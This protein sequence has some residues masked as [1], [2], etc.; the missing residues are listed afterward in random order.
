MRSRLREARKHT[1]LRIVDYAVLLD[2]SRRTVERWEAG[3]R[4][5]SLVELCR[6][7]TLAGL[8]VTWLVSDLDEARGE[9]ALG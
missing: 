4:A 2:V 7:A 5:P 6:I 3:T 9:I 8:S 1:G